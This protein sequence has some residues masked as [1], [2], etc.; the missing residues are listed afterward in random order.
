ML[1]HC[2]SSSG[3]KGAGDKMAA[4]FPWAIMDLL[5]IL[6]DCFSISLLMH[7]EKCKGRRNQRPY[8]RETMHSE[9]QSA[10]NL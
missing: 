2:S 6:H 4:I 9:M 5:V 3:T 7:T 10:L 1:T 8:I